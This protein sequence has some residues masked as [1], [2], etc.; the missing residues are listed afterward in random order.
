MVQTEWDD[1]NTLHPNHSTFQPWGKYTPPTS[2]F[3]QYARLLNRA[4][5]SVML[6]TVSNKIFTAA[7]IIRL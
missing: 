4:E 5:C 3:V 6:R 2:L 7:Y 1:T